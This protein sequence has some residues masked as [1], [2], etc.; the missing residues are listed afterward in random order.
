MVFACGCAGGAPLLH[1]AH[2]LRPGNVAFA[3]GVSGRFAPLM[4]EASV[5]GERPLAPQLYDELASAPGIAP[6]VA[7]R[8]GIE[9][10]N[11]AGL[12]YSARSVRLDGRHAFDIAPFTLSLGL[13]GSFILPKSL[14]DDEGSI[15]G[16]GADIPAIVGWRSDADL[17]SVWFGPRVGFEVLDGQVSGSLLSEGGSID[18]YEDV[19]GYQILAGGLFGF[20]I[21]FRSIFVSAEVDVSYHF[22]SGTLGGT[23][24]TLSQVSVTPASALWIHF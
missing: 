15:K 17:Y 7:G 6:V 24:V 1:P 19:S 3:G 10:D 11:E 13:G 12:T 20:R 2:V 4:Q 18:R 5:E 14:G 23:D 16:G 22:G 8:V 9:G 21:G